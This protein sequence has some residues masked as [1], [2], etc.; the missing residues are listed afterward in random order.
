MTEAGQQIPHPSRASQNLEK[1]S[2]NEHPLYRGAGIDCYLCALRNFGTT[3][4]GRVW[5]QPA[6][7]QHVR[8]TFCPQLQ[9]GSPSGLA[10]VTGGRSGRVK[11]EADWLRAEMDITA[12]SPGSAAP[13]ASPAAGMCL[14]QDS[15]NMRI[16][17]NSRDILKII[18][19]VELHLLVVLEL[20]ALS[21][22]TQGLAACF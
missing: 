12:L 14:G 20:C 7:Q 16:N 22:F 9:S 10:G 6:L 4:E 1:T 2:W 19:D 18:I 3:Q 21:F 8:V 15:G 17:L 5:P 11:E 13:L